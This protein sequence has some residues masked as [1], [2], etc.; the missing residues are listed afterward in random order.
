MDCGFS[1]RR[2]I[3]M[4]RMMLK[5]AAVAAAWIGLTAD[6]SQAGLLPVSLSETKDV[7]NSRYSYGVVLTSDS[8]LKT[9]DYFTIYD[10]AGYVPGTNLQPAGFTFSSAK[11][12][13]T[14]AGI[15]PTDNP[16]IPNVTWTYTG[17]TTAVGQASLGN[18]S[19]DSTFGSS[20]DGVFTSQTHRQ[21]DGKTDSNITS[22]EVP[23][24]SAPGVPEPAS[25][26]LLGIGLPLVGAF[27]Y[28]RRRS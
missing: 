8:T 22:A 5:L 4:R 18:F 28:L 3:G 23:V 13:P 20:V 10:F 17:P 21:V 12:G 15:A 16:S 2:E 6:V 24:P 7:G 27:R 11:L 19:V 9:G 14:P 25:L 1:S 26:V